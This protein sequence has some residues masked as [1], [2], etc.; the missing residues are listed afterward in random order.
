METIERS[1]PEY[2][3]IAAYIRQQQ[4]G[5]T[6][7][8]AEAITELLVRAWRRLMAPP[9]AAAVPINGRYDRI[10]ERELILGR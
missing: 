3:P 6:V 5:G 7:V 2:A 9:P 8:I 10:A 4:L 1:Y